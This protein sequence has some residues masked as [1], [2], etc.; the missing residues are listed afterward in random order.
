MTPS[1]SFNEARAAAAR[2]LAEEAARADDPRDALLHQM[3]ADDLT[4]EITP[5]EQAA[6]DAL[7]GED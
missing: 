1:T 6:I 5:D 3:A 4:R 2:A 7:L